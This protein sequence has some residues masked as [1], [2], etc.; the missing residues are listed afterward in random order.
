[1]RPMIPPTHTIRSQMAMPYPPTQPSDGQSVPIMHKLEILFEMPN[2]FFFVR[3][4]VSPLTPQQQHQVP[5]NSYACRE[6]SRLHNWKG[7]IFETFFPSM[8][9]F[10]PASCA[11]PKDTR[12]IRSVS[13]SRGENKINGCDSDNLVPHTSF[14]L[15]DVSSDPLAQRRRIYKR[16][17][18]RTHKMIH[19]DLHCLATIS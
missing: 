16:I 11:F 1:M 10:F 14:L 9:T 18:K 6:S 8:E 19:K 13:R 7:L 2:L 3:D 5:S 17:H 4:C 12:R 15:N